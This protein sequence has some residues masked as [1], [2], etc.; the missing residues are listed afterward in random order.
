M[1]LQGRGMFD[2][3]QTLGHYLPWLRHSDK[4]DIVLRDMLAHQAALVPFIPFYRN[5]MNEDYTFRTGIFNEFPNRKF[6]LQ[7]TDS[8]FMDK[9]YRK[10]MFR[11]IRDSKL[12]P[13]KYV[14]SDL[15]F[16]LAAEIVKSLTDTTIDKFAEANIYC[17]LGAFDITFNPHHKYPL[18]RIVPTEYDTLFRKQLIRGT[19]HDEN[20]AMLG[21]VSGHAGLFAT[22]NDL[23]KLMEMYRRG[24]EYG[25]VRI[26]N[27]E[28]LKEYTT[29]QFPENNNRRGLGFDKPSLPNDTIPRE[30]IYPCASAS[31][32]SFGHSG[33]TGTFVWVDPEAEI[34][35]VFLSNHIYPT[36]QNSK[37]FDLGIRGRILQ[38]VYDAII[39]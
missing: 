30:E 26:I 3:D 24:G 33:F 20:A 15:A 19:V 16:I 9:G 37:L 14:Y 35:Y 1:V 22:G 8:M 36:R 13:K 32:S 12:G 17:P 10:E 38:A 31:P 21:G 29:V 11:E 34:S 39:K 28:V 18:E 6:A 4:A 27:R 5:T 7:V 2:P 25:G 23:L